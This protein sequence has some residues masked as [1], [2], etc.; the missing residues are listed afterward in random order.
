[1]QLQVYKE[2]DALLGN[3]DCCRLQPLISPI[4]IN[5]IS[6]ENFK[7]ITDCFPFYSKRVFKFKIILPLPRQVK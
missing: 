1:M 2:F 3:P 5:D 6:C 7:S 4:I